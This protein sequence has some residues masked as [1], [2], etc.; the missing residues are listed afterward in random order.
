[1]IITSTKSQWLSADKHPMAH[2]L[3][4]W[5]WENKELANR[6]MDEEGRIPVRFFSNAHSVELIVNGES[7]GVQT[8]TKK[9]TADGRPTKK[10]QVQTNSIWSGWC[11]TYLV[12]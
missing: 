7:R 3:P 9:T 10:G 2:L 6:V 5:N 12:K 11:L 4:H 1:M 8:F